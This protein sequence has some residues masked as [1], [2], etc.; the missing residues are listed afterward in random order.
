MKL[1][2]DLTAHGY[3]LIVRA[4]DRMFAVSVSWGCTGTKATLIEVIKEARSM[5]G[6]CQWMNDKGPR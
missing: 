3:K 5:I 4:P 2:P 1:P 6:F